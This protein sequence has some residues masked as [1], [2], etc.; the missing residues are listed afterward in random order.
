MPI[1][2]QQGLAEVV[3]RQPDKQAGP[4]DHVALAV[5]VPADRLQLR[6]GLAGEQL[7]RRI[8]DDLLALQEAQ[9][10]IVAAYTTTTSFSLSLE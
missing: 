3:L 8:A 1:V 4:V 5:Q 9:C 10:T 6:A 2:A 7:Q